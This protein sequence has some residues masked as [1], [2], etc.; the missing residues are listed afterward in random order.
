MTNRNEFT[1]A[2]KD[3]AFKRSGGMPLCTVDGCLRPAR[4]HLAGICHTHYCRVYRGWP[5]PL[6]KPRR[7]CKICGAQVVTVGGNGVLCQTHKRKPRPIIR[8]C[9]VC[10]KS[11]SPKGR[12]LVCSE[13]CMTKR[14]YIWWR[15]WY[16]AVRSTGPGRDRFRQKEYRR[17]LTKKQ[18]DWEEFERDEIFA[19]DNWICGICREPVNRQAVWPARDFATIDHIKPLVKGGGH[20]RANVQCAHLI[21]NTKKN[22]HDMGALQ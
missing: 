5:A 18:G 6:M 19:R 7:A 15:N 16:N 3:A 8:D 12:L 20:T 1:Q 9:T 21:C 10:G 4:S 11:I 22:K 17:K 14:E 13:E 2:T